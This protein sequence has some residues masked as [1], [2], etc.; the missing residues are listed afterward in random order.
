MSGCS[1]N[2][3]GEEL[4]LNGSDDI[5]ENCCHR[6]AVSSGEPSLDGSVDEERAALSDSDLAGVARIQVIF[7]YSL[8]RSFRLE[9]KKSSM[10]GS[11]F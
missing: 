2:E 9:K 4:Q 7:C 3:N 8:T 10:I 11:R 1:W 6:R 5:N